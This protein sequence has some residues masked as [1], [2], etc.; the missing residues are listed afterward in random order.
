MKLDRRS[1]LGLFGA[2]P[3]AGVA[4]ERPKPSLPE[5]HNLSHVV[6]YGEKLLNVPLKEYWLEV[7]DRFKVSCGD[8]W[9]V[10][11]KSVRFN[12]GPPVTFDLINEAATPFPSNFYKL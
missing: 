3:V 10:A 9:F 2:A 11:S 8:V 1:L 5:V 12:D 7:G 4:K 6:M